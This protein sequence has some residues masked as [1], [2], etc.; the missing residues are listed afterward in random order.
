[1]WGSAVLD[2]AMG[3][4]FGFLAISLFTSAAVEVINS[5]FGL[6][7]TTLKAGV[8]ALLND[9][10][11]TDLAKKIYQHAAVN[12]LSPGGASIPGGN[13]ENKNLPSY[14]DKLQFAGALLD[15][16]GL[17]AES[18][19]GAAQA[20][21]PQAVAAFKARIDQLKSSGQIDGQIAQLLDGIVN[22]TNGDI[23]QIQNQLASWFDAAMDRVGGTFKRWTL[24]WTLLIALPIAVVFNMDSIRIGTLLWEQPFFADS[25]KSPKL[26]P[27]SDG[28]PASVDE[29]I[30]T[31][32]RALSD[33]GTMA[34]AGLPVGWANG[35]FFQA[36]DVDGSWYP[37]WKK[38]GALLSSLLGWLVT[39][40]AALFGA[41]FWFDSLQTII[42][43]KGS[44][45]SPAEKA[46][47]G[48]ASN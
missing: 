35:H 30:A 20:P 19:I 2:V 46:S 16:T 33:I 26:A 10:N 42:R 44:G 34:Q 13:G 32:Q 5:F 22:R 14:I 40:V 3:V 17:S 27:S 31:E 15:I 24:V 8:Q 45:P 7:A 28:V 29:A 25:L 38:P 9:P 12:P 18:A 43:L 6:R 41:P 21:G 1:M 39:A 4:V 23:K 36:I 47:G 37:L 11:F 48:A